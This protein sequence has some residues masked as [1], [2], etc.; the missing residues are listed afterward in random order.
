MELTQIILKGLGKAKV[1]SILKKWVIDQI[2]LNLECRSLEVG[3]YQDFTFDY[4][5]RGYGLPE[6]DED[7]NFH[8]DELFEFIG[9]KL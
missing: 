5:I 3:Q 6:V 2:N 7:H 1:R 9:N 8:V 4:T